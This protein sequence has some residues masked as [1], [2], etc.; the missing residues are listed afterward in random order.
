[1]VGVAVS[2]ENTVGEGRPVILEV[3]DGIGVAEA[4]AVGV[5]AWAVERA[6]QIGGQGSSFALF[7]FQSLFDKKKFRWQNL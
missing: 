6:G 4:V 3:G 2:S 1:M 5:S 7:T